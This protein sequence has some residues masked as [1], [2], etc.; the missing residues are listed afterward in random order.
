MDSQ[1]NQLNKGGGH[2]D[3]HW[4]IRPIHQAQHFQAKVQ[5]QAHR[6]SEGGAIP[7]TSTIIIISILD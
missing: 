5:N 4:I 7:L 1:T 2:N 3:Q 6:D